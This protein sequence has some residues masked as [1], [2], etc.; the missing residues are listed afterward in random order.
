MKIEIV[1]LSDIHFESSNNPISKKFPQ[2]VSAITNIEPEIKAYIL[3]FSGDI[4][5]SGQK[6]QFKAAEEFYLNL[7]CEI[8]NNPGEILVKS[9]FVPGNHDCDLSEENSIRALVVEKIKDGKNIDTAFLD[10]ATQPQ[11]NFF[12]FLENIGDQNVKNKLLWTSEFEIEN[13]KIAI[14]C[15]N[16]AWMSTKNE[17]QGTLRFPTE[18]FDQRESTNS[19]EVSVFHHPYNWLESN[20]ARKFKDQV[21]D[22][23]DLIL[24]GHE[25]N[26]ANYCKEN[27]N[28]TRNEFFEGGVLNETGKPSK[29]SFNIVLIDFE[30]QKLKKVSYEFKSGAYKEVVANSNNWSPFK[31]NPAQLK[32]T[33]QLKGK[34]LEDIDDLGLACSHP[35][36]THISLNDLFVF[37]DL[38]FLEKEINPEDSKPLKTIKSAKVKDYILQNNKILIVG[39][40]FSG[41]SALAKQSVNLF[42]KADLVPIFLDGSKI[43]SS[44]LKQE[45]FISYI[46]EAF[47]AQ[48]ENTE[49]GNFQLLPKEKKAVV[50]DNFHL[51]RINE[52]GKIKLIELLNN[53]FGYNLLFADETLKFE[54]INY[55]KAEGKPFLDFINLEVLPFSKFLRHQVIE[56]W[57]TLGQE[58]S[59]NNH[60]FIREV[61]Q[62]ERILSNV[63][64]SNM[65]PSVPVFILIMLQQIEANRQHLL[66]SGSYGELFEFIISYKLG[67]FNTGKIDLVTLQTY[68]SEFAFILFKSKKSFVSEEEM[69]RFHDEH[70]KNFAIKLDYKKVID[71]L[72]ACTIFSKGNDL[73]HFKYQFSY[74]YFLAKYLADHFHEKEIENV[75]GEI[76]QNIH[77][78]DY[79]NT[80]IFL[81]HFSKNP[82][83]LDSVLGQLNSVFNKSAC[84]DFSEDFK[85]LNVLDDRIN[86]ELFHPE[87]T[88]PMEVRQKVN[89]IADDLDK[90]F[91]EEDYSLDESSDFNKASKALQVAG[92]ILRSYAGSLTTEKKIQLTKA[93]YSLGMR[94]IK[95]FLDKLELGLNDI[96]EAFYENIKEGKSIPT[97]EKSKKMIKG[98]IY[99]LSQIS[100]ISF[101]KK[102]SS[103]VG[104]PILQL[105]FKELLEKEN[106]LGNIFID[107]SIKL[108][109]YPSF[110]E[111][112]IKD[113]SEKLKKEPFN[114]AILKILTLTHFLMF[115][116]NIAL[117]QKVCG[118]LKIP[119]KK[120]P[121]LKPKN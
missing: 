55:L 9:I 15:F 24:T 110:P 86:I 83:I 37:P 38:K 63:M 23:A 2:L 97:E 72:L 45:T 71:H 92:Q 114:M 61:D 49:W 3:V 112:V 33:F 50:L 79:A 59:W 40:Q 65:I 81:S 106:N 111:S 19:L 108:D 39:D 105:T 88:S 47:E 51:L 32:N 25:H 90:K 103:S 42:R 12:N 118:W 26:Q 98:F 1:H 30:S 20:N 53:N 14:N 78:E 60:D 66:V 102:V 54:E 5:F 117:R 76:V 109:H 48:Y 77:R 31:K 85:F 10:L 107:L 18:I 84:C 82:I 4:T 57:L 89:N 21:E 104:S 27:S 67:E 116:E 94:S 68:L 43:N 34:F 80:V 120:I 73:L 121:L 13:E 95:A 11:C 100:V 28:S 62:I 52:K 93:C 44:N 119:T 99:F 115:E 58:Y 6:E 91:E 8:E 113:L 29:S 7:L 64:D 96:I 35:R 56:K 17:K 46:H 87:Y 36:K 16:T 101:I 74:Y 22:R 41:K 69:E 70:L 75:F